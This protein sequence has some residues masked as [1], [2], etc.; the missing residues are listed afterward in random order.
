M[1]TKALIC[2]QGPNNRCFLQKLENVSTE[3]PYIV[4][5]NKKVF[6]LYDPPHLLKNVRNNFK[7]SNYK[8]GDV[9]VKWE[10]IVDFYNMDKVMSIRMAPKLTDK[11]II[12]PPFSTMK[13]SL[14]A[15]TL[16]H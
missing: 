10:C 7:K 8:Y 6:V 2:D 12:V 11:H 5:N 16:S 1:Q 3:R 14:A 9:E 13:V 15:Q 4:T